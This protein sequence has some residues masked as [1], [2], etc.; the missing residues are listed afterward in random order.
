MRAMT[1]LQG[2]RS[3]SHLSPGICGSIERRIYLL[4]TLNSVT[5]WSIMDQETSYHEEQGISGQE[6]EWG[7]HSGLDLVIHSI[8]TT[9]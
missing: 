5:F 4:V 1:T 9:V 3:L 7:F 2:R 8:V 6:M